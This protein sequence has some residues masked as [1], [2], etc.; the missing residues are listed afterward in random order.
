M[1][2]AQAA[3]RQDLHDWTKGMLGRLDATFLQDLGANLAAGVTLVSD[4]SGMMCAEMTLGMTLRELGRHG[5]DVSKTE[6]YSTCDCDKC[7]RTS[8]DR[9][10]APLHRSTCSGTFCIAPL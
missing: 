10:Q 3:C 1:P 6:V 9:T 7:H 4:Y 8:C 5:I 2:R